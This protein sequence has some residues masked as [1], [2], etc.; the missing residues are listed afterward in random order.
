[1]SISKLKYIK[2][3]EIDKA[4]WDDCINSANNSRAYA[5]FDYLERV[6]L[7]WDALIL[8]DYKYVMPLPIRKKAGIKYVY[9]P[10]S[11][12]QLG[13]FPTPSKEITD[14]FIDQLKQHFMYCDILLNTGN[15]TLSET[16]AI[17]R[18]NFLLPLDKDYETICSSFSKNTKRNI[19]K[20]KQNNLMLLENIQLNDFLSFKAKNQLS[21]KDKE[22]L[23]I[24]KNIISYGLY[25]NAGQI[26]GVYTS[27]NEL[28]AAVYFYRWK[29][30]IIYLNALSSKEGKELKAMFFLVNRFIKNHAKQN[31]TLDFE[32]SMIPGVARFYESFGATA[33]IYYHLKI[34]Q[35]PF[36]FK[37]IKK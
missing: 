7:K 15:N 30:R 17:P 19:S 28:C 3:N 25:K 11:A 18:N 23:N 8:D 10:P 34:N 37:W 33:E 20:A 13:I 5:H 16:E 27:Q 9:Q 36:P 29:D 4:K 12:Q 22:N 21:G 35:L 26:Y 24:L 31:F 1:M 32:G 6:A 14:H 2:H